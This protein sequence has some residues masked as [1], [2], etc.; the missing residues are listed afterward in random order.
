M[1]RSIV[2]LLIQNYVLPTGRK[3]QMC[4][5]CLYGNPFKTRA[6]MGEELC[7]CRLDSPGS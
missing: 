6:Y 7:G 2:R 3:L 1:F 4:A 5:E